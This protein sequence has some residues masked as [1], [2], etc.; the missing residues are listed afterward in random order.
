MF[1]LSSLYACQSALGAYGLW[2]SLTSIS[3][4]QQ[5]ESQT[6]TAAKWSAGA[7][8]QLYKARTTQT[9]G[10]LTVSSMNSCCAMIRAIHE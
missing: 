9:S 3:R 6:K 5:Y 10:A 1:V 4:I 8:Q 2:L 7:E